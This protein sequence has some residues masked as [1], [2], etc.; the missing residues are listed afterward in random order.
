MHRPGCNPDDVQMSDILCDFCEAPWTH[1]L[2]MVEG[3]H[4]A[5]ICGGCLAQAYRALVLA[6]AA[7]AE[8]TAPQ[9]CSLCLET[10]DEP[11]WT[12]PRRAQAIACRRCVRQSAAVLAKDPDSGWRRPEA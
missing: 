10:R 8:G 1:E 3:H 12:S 6:A 7:P 9:P 5:C 2:P 4:G 11:A